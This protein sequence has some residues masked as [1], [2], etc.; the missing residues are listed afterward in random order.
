VTAVNR[1]V[2]EREATGK[3]WS[4]D[5]AF[6][7]L[8]KHFS[9]PQIARNRLDQA[10]RAGEITLLWRKADRPWTA[11]EPRFLTLFITVSTFDAADGIHANLHAV[12]YTPGPDLNEYEWALSAGE[13]EALCT[14]ATERNS[15][16]VEP[17]GDLEK[18]RWD[19]IS[20]ELGRQIYIG[21]I[22]PQKISD[23]AAAALMMTFCS[24]KWNKYPAES[25]MRAKV[26]GWLNSYR[27]SK[28]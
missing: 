13:V 3:R 7:R 18:Y 14:P 12:G 8:L 4:P 15:P 23:R 28:L 24:E 10:I 25:Q 6:Q 5:E 22:D 26:S 19:E 27:A 17:R 9:N 2:A 11:D 1:P 16:E 20:T 21:E